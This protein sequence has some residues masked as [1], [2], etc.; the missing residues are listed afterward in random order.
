MYKTP[1]L[2]QKENL[3][4]CTSRSLKT[5]YTSMSEVTTDLNIYPFHKKEQKSLILPH[6]QKE[7]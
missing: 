1:L 2:A 3:S 4:R 7:L 5:V 6:L